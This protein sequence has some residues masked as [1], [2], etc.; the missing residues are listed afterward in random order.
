MTTAIIP[1][2]GSGLPALIRAAGPQA[3][4]RTAEFFVGQIANANTCKAYT[5]AVGDCMT[6]CEGMGVPSIAAVQPLHVS[7]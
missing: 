2:Q 3:A 7:L 5:R 6:W 1:R 4:T